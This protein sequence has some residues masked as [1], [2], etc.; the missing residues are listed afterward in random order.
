MCLYCSNICIDFTSDR[1]F[2]EVCKTQYVPH[3]FL[4]FVHVH[5]L[6]SRQTMMDETNATEFKISTKKEFKINR[7]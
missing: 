3:I 4:M 2:T 1:I 7:N 6:I 5:V